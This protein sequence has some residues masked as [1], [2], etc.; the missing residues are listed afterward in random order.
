MSTASRFQRLCLAAIAC[1]VC[2]PSGLEARQ[3]RLTSSPFGLSS[4]PESPAPCAPANRI[5]IAT[6][7]GIWRSG[8]LYRQTWLSGANPHPQPLRVEV[9]VRFDGGTT[10]R[11]T[12]LVPTMDRW[13]VNLDEVY[14]ERITN[15]LQVNATVRVTCDRECA[16]SV[17]LWHRQIGQG[18]PTVYGLP[19]VCV[20]TRE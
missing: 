16:A 14:G 11:R 20:G 6:E 7:A 17:A 9:E 3:I 18:E 2:A 15:G 10:G 12:F 13:A 1:Y 8:G 4:N 19:F 5:G